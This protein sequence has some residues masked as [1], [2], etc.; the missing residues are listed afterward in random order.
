MCETQVFRKDWKVWSELIPTPWV[1][2]VLNF[3]RKLVVMPKHDE[4][5]YGGVDRSGVEVQDERG[6]QQ[7]RDRRLDGRYAEALD[8]TRMKAPFITSSSKLQA[9]NAPRTNSFRLG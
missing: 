6:G 8:G 3:R 2:K 4:A 7:Q 5:E 9:K 1:L